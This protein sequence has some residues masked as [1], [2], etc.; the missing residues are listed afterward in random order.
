[1]R[2][3]YCDH[4]DSYEYRQAYPRTRPTWRDALRASWRLVVGTLAVYGFV[5]GYFAAAW[6]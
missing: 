2:R 5:V 1:M 4:C 6:R 3:V